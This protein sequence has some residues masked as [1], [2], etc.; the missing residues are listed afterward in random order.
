MIRRPPRST[1]SSSSAASDV[2]KRQGDRGR[3]LERELLADLDA[4]LVER[5]D[6]PDDALREC[7]VLVQRDQLP[8][9]ARGERR[10]HDRRGRP[11]ALEHPRADDR[12]SGALG[13]YLVGRLPVRERLGLGEEVREEQLVYVLVAVLQRVRR[14]GDGDEVGRDQLGALMDELV[15]RMLPVRAGLAPE[16]LAGRGRDRLAVSAYALAVR[17]HRQLLQVRGE[18]V[19]VLRVGQDLSLIHISE[20]TRLLSISYAV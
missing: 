15:E 1:L 4:P 20:P 14:R 16:D 8:H 19:Q 9:H 3:D 18:A 6:A 12:L 5:V 13:P 7:D 10:R 2:Y 17:L 11:V